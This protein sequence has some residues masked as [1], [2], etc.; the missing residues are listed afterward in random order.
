MN[1]ILAQFIANLAGVPE[2]DVLVLEEKAPEFGAL[3]RTAQKLAPMLEQADGLVEKLAPQVDAML[4]DLEKL[5]AL[6]KQI[7]TTTAPQK[8][9][10]EA[11]VG[12]L[13]DIVA[14]KAS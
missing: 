12:A 9:N 10:F 13:G 3:C 4:P 7:S 2:K 1:P 11:V 8:A 14:S 5:F 6:F